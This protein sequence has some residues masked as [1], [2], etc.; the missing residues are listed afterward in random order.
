M[1]SDLHAYVRH[2]YFRSFRARTGLRVLW[3]SCPLRLPRM[4][5]LFVGPAF[6]LQLPSDPA[7]RRTPL[8]FG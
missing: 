8:L 4:W 7:S 1:H 3:P 2:I 6:C 5:F